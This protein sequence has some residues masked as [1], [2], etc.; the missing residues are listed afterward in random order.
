MRVPLGWLRE[1]VDI[2]WGAEEL[3]ERLTMS[4]VKVEALHRMGEELR[5]LVCARI[6]GVSLHPRSSALWVCRVYDGE[7][8]RQVV[9]GAP[10][11]E[12]GQR[13]AY[14]RPGAVLAG[15]QEIGVAQFGGETSEGMLLSA[16]ELV[17]GEEHREGE[18][19]LQ[20][21]LGVSPGAD[22][23]DYFGLRETVLEL[24]LTVNYAVHCQSII[25]VAYE[26]AALTGGQVPLPRLFAERYQPSL[27]A[28]EEA[29]GEAAQLTS[30]RVEDPELCPRYTALLLRDV[31]PGFSPVE[32]QFRL[33][34]AGMR[35]LGAVVDATNYV[36]LETGQPLHAFDL[37][38]LTGERI[39]V[40]R[41]REGER[42]LTLDGQERTLSGEM[43]VIADAEKAVGLAG[44]M[45]GADSEVSPLTGHLLL[46]A[47]WFDPVSI[48]RTSRRLGLRTE[49]ASRFEKGIDPAAVLA[50]SYR[51][52]YLLEEMGAA[53]LI[54]GG[55]DVRKAAYAPRQA[56]L[57]PQ[58]VRAVLGVDLGD[59]DISDHL[60][61][62]GFQ[63]NTAAGDTA[64]GDTAAGWLVTIP[65]RRG[66]VT[67]EIDLIE[68][69]ARLYGYD[70][71]PSTLPAGSAT[72]TLTHQQQWIEEA[73][74]T[75]AA[76]GLAEAVTF[77]LVNPD[78]FDRL[79]L[80]GDDPRR[81]ALTVRNP[82][83]VEWSLLRTTLLPGLL[84]S[85]RHNLAHRV[86]RAGLFEIAAVYLPKT[87]PPQDLPE[88][89]LHVAMAAYGP[90]LGRH[91]RERSGNVDYF[92]MKG[93]AEHFLADLGGTLE[94]VPSQ[95]PYLHPGRQARIS[96]GK[97][98]LGVIGELHPRVSR[99]WELVDPVSVCE[100]DFSTVM[101]LM[102][103][104]GGEPHLRPVPRFP[105][106]VRDVALSLPDHIPAA[107]AEEI[108]RRHA[109]PFLE[110]LVLFDLY[111]GEGIPAGHRSLAYSLT[112][113]SPER[114]LTDRE[115]DDMHAQV[116]H[117]LEVELGAVLR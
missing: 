105:A 70:R 41:A 6:V 87:L 109:G 78:V 71:I 73:R 54:P 108:I 72:G 113:R 48:S 17:L 97:H 98:V 65:T 56:P 3:A 83:S 16:T 2:P 116:R 22:L 107:Q 100:L 104:S 58:R 59:R 51:A 106:V 49:A 43:L 14:A 96:I 45:G 115:V 91:W 34:A 10:G 95:E 29:W 112:Y 35:P 21:P 77:T 44:V 103:E 99:T 37:K 114:T 5:G 110:S 89:R 69:V 32:I 30:V 86:P 38:R 4:G 12:V 101:G 92:F 74:R 75:L 111:R 26:V 66:D 85:L 79:R 9:T 63:V 20:L 13:V 7:G 102:E 90:W 62:L 28:G 80:A 19:I 94:F 39:V 117:A 40:R 81:R 8:T 61:R 57:R 24:E 33:H 53:R 11:L 27:P 46:E 82:L 76:A 68:E 50:A 36:M 42:L 1:Y 84:E 15:G 18:G 88:E 23:A 55:I 31:K 64:A 60:G 67:Q 93:I 47:A 25:G 52:A